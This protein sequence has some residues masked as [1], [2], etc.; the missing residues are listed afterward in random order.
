MLPVVVGEKPTLQAI[1]AYSAVVTGVSL[2]LFLTPPVGW[3][4]LVAAAVLG[5]VLM[6]SAVRLRSA[7]QRAMSFFGYSNVYLAGLFVAMA[8]DA[9]I[10]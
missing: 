4:Y 1:L 10:S 2:L 3:V 9:V 6:V 7:P 8:V 5:A